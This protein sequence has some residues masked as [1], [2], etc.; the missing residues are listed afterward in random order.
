MTKPVNKSEMQYTYFLISPWERGTFRDD[1][2]KSYK[3]RFPN[4]VKL[5]KKQRNKIIR[6]KGKNDIN[7][8]LGE[9]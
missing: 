6:K 8:E 4:R 3:Q 2:D 9:L 7:V 5:A 1:Y